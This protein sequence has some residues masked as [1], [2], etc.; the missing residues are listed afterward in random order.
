MG[1]YICNFFFNK[2]ALFPKIE[3]GSLEVM[4]IFT[5]RGVTHQ[6]VLSAHF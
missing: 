1:N 3:P 2:K 5:G 6:Q 4:S